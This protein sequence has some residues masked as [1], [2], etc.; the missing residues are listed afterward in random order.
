MNTVNCS[1][2][3][4]F[5]DT[6]RDF[7]N[8][9][10]CFFTVEDNHKQLKMGI[11]AT[12]NEGETLFTLSIVKFKNHD[13]AFSEQDYEKISKYVIAKA[14]FGRLEREYVNLLTGS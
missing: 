12:T 3:K 11:K 1:T 13:G 7:K 10:D 4:E 2:A 8:K 6:L 14:E 5:V 9:N